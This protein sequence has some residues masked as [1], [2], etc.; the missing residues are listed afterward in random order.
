MATN[1]FEPG[2]TIQ[3]TWV[4]ST[5]PDSAPIVK[6]TGINNTIIN[7]LTSISSDST[8]YYAMYTLPSSEGFYISEWNAVKT[9]QSSAYN[10]VK[11]MVF[12]IE[13]TKA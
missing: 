7:S 9:V 1:V 13:P 5:A 2:N 8:H 12:R 4:S 11:K 10:F 6:I 3:F